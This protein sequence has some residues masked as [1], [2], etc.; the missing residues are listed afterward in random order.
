MFSLE[1]KTALI[2]GASGGIGAAIARA[3]H[4]QGATVVLSGTRKARFPSWRRNWESG[5]I[6]ASRI[7]PMPPKRMRWSVRRRKR[8]DSRWIFSSIMR[9]SR[10][11]A[12]P[13]VCGIR[14]G[15]R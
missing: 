1:G 5:R 7:C 15:L 12:L 10:G 3:L 2:T 14:I 4:R 8:R 13:S 11:M 6:F 9:A